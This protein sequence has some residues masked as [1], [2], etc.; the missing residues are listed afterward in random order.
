M[1]HISGKKRVT[2][3]VMSKKLGVARQTVIN[4]ENN[5]DIIPC[6]I[7]KKLS[8]LSGATIDELTADDIDNDIV[9]PSIA[10]V[11]DKL[12]RPVEDIIKTIEVIQEFVLNP[13]R[14]FECD[15]EIDRTIAGIKEKL[16][17]ERKLNI[18]IC[19]IAGTGKS[20]LIN[21]ILGEKVIPVSCFYGTPALTYYHHISEKPDD[22][23]GKNDTVITCEPISDIADKKEKKI[24]GYHSVLLKAYVKN[25]EGC[26]IEDGYTIK[27]I[28]VYLDNKN[29]KGCSI[30]DTPRLTWGTSFFE[31]VSLEILKQ[32]YVLL[33][34]S[35]QRMLESSHEIF[36]IK[37]L[38]E[39][40]RNDF[41]IC[42][43]IVI[44][45]LDLYN[46]SENPGK[47]AIEACKEKLLSTVS[48]DEKSYIE[49]KYND[50]FLTVDIY[51]KELSRIFDDSFSD[52]VYALAKE[53]FYTLMENIENVC[54]LTSKDYSARK[55]ILSLELPFNDNDKSKFQSIA[56][57]LFQKRGKSMCD[58]HKRIALKNYSDRFDEITNVKSV[59]CVIKEKKIA[60][61]ADLERLLATHFK[62]EFGRIL[63][64]ETDLELDK[65]RDWFASEVDK[66]FEYSIDNMDDDLEAILDGFAERYE[67][68]SFVKNHYDTEKLKKPDNADKNLFNDSD[69]DNKIKEIFDMDEISSRE[70]NERLSEIISS[71]YK[72]SKDFFI[73]CCE[74][75]WENITDEFFKIM[76]MKIEVLQEYTFHEKRGTSEEA[77][78]RA[79]DYEEAAKVIEKI[80]QKCRDKIENVK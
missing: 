70:R 24:I 79:A 27:Q 26:T 40:E 17:G 58:A 4:Y 8:T 18:A 30:L 23:Y 28:D 53:K 5:P 76:R 33:A 80:G 74:T 42:P 59:F 35:S 51:N 43:N 22:I 34:T 57:D 50:K 60:Q 7:L 20:S 73:T 37:A 46:D 11:Y 16:K 72:S 1:N 29:L 68:N 65:F 31:E 64:E 49:E 62:D 13:N 36:F 44:T 25:D 69:Y 2:Y 15:K 3:D 32:D 45:Y 12:C 52:T 47:S 77:A 71:L 75:M 55:N 61:F 39:T 63:K 19:G 66:L 54:S 14:T 21:H 56:D 9:P 10:D 48:E 41:F 67:L 38:I 6:S 78:R